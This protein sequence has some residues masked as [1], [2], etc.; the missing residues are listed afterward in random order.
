[1][2]VEV[3]LSELLSLSKSSSQSH[4]FVVGEKYLIRTVTM[5]FTGRVKSVTDSDVEL[6]DAAWIANT[7]R[8]YDSLQS[9]DLSEVEPYPQNV[10][11]G[12]GGIIDFT[13]WKHEL[14]RSQV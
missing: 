8:F 2:K 7:G 5:H 9:G 11:V 3:E 10:F 14:P 4:S 13:I 12:R 1:M 6:E